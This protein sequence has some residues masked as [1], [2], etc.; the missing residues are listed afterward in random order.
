MNL[1]KKQIETL[2]LIADS[3]EGS[4]FEREVRQVLGVL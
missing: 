1:T 3:C 4:E 2:Y